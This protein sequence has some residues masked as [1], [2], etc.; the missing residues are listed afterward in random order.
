IDKTERILFRNQSPTFSG[1]ARRTLQSVGAFALASALCVGLLASGA[2]AEAPGPR[3]TPPVQAIVDRAT[4]ALDG[5]AP[6]RG[7]AAADSA[8]ALAN[9]DA[10]SI[11]VAWALF[12]RAAALQ[13][14]GQKQE[15][16][17][18]LMETGERWHRLGAGPEE[19]QVM[20]ARAVFAAPS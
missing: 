13:V 14:L 9:L 1:L 7:L 16:F 17:Q 4:Q 5:R 19:L 6:D 12:V 20:C 2:L 18:V 3:G 15:A 8:L 11:G 10:D